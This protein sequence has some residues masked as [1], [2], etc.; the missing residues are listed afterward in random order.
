MFRGT[1]YRQFLSD[2]FVGPSAFPPK[3]EKCWR[4]VFRQMND[5]EK[6]DVLMAHLAV[7]NVPL[8]A[9]R[10]L[11]ECFD[12]GWIKGGPRMYYVMLE[13]RTAPDES[14]EERVLR[15][16]KDG[17]F[18]C[19][20]T[21][22]RKLTRDVFHACMQAGFL[23]ILEGDT[24]RRSIMGTVMS[25]A[26]SR[27]IR[28][29]GGQGSSSGLRT[30]ALSEDFVDCWNVG[31]IYTRTLGQ[32]ITSHILEFTTLNDDVRIDDHAF[33]AIKSQR[34]LDLIRQTRLGQMCGSG[35]VERMGSE[36]TIVRKNGKEYFGSNASSFAIKAGIHTRPHVDNSQPL[37]S[38]W[39]DE[40]PCGIISPVQRT[41]TG[42]SKRAVIVSRHDKGVAVKVLGL[43]VTKT[44][45]DQCK[46]QD[47]KV[48]SD[49][50]SILKKNRIGYVLVD[51]PRLC[52]Y[53]IP[54]GCVH[55][56]F[57]IGMTETTTWFPSLKNVD[58]PE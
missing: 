41:W 56:F 1:K 25:E 52:T 40:A 16:E 46:R 21:V 24:P 47:I 5:I 15:T 55:M 27:Q 42:P 49:L 57:T 11:G 2:R 4:Q 51:F 38:E 58:L 39:V 44:P 10:V 19:Q 31:D 14:G 28:K 53:V 37:D 3:P 20:G 36:T 13:K 48:L 22:R 26:L 34:G 32:T 17:S 33:S 8:G 43:D 30:I 9:R 29:F 7:N 54:R 6:R 23:Y 18:W 12:K 35:E 45:F 50:V